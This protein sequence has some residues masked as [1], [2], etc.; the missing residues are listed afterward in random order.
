MNVKNRT[1]VLDN[2]SFENESYLAMCDHI[3]DNISKVEFQFMCDYTLY[4]RFLEA[5]KEKF[6][7]EDSMVETVVDYD[8]KKKEFYKS[9]SEYLSLTINTK[10]NNPKHCYGIKYG[11]ST[12]DFDEEEMDFTRTKEVIYSTTL[13]YNSKKYDKEIL[14]WFETRINETLDKAGLDKSHFYLIRESSSGLKLEQCPITNEYPIDI[15]LNYGKEFYNKYEYILDVLKNKYKGIVLFYGEPGTG[16]SSFLRYLIKELCDFKSV[17]Y[18]PSNM[19]YSISNPE[20]ISL[21]KMN[22]GSILILE[23]AESVIQERDGST[24]DQAVSNILNLTDGILNDA[25]KIQVIAT[26]NTAKDHI[27]QALLRSGRLIDAHEF[28]P[29]SPEQANKVAKSLG[30]EG[31]Y[32]KPTTL[33]QIYDEFNAETKLGNNTSK[34]KKK[35]P[36]KVG[37]VQ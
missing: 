12:I 31:N 32:T 17:I 9:T 27:D 28:L 5:M 29:L 24:N 34:I 11:V 20:F 19:M 16:K 33:S 36:N 3:G 30:K 23:D 13:F 6:D 10:D 2:N 22:K 7:I 8:T 18:V 4:S 1:I 14:D 25:L 21:V 35:K 37:F 26:F 15:K